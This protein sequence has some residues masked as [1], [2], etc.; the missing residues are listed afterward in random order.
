MNK[1]VYAIIEG[2]IDDEF[3]LVLIDDPNIYKDQEVVFTYI[4]REVP[5][6]FYE[7]SDLLEEWAPY[8]G[9]FTIGG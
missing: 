1:R 8:S 2:Y 6:T 5:T 9:E 7:M 4:D 3:S